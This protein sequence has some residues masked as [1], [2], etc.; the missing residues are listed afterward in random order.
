MCTQSLPFITADCYI[1]IDIILLV[2]TECVT[3]VAIITDFILAEH[4]QI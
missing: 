4:P 3:I 1:A 2:H